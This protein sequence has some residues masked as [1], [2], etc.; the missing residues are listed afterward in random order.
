MS[1]HR[2]TQLVHLAREHNALIITD[3]VYDRLQWPTTSLISTSAS[4]TSAHLDHAILPRLTDLDRAL[5][6]HPSDPRQFR[7][8]LSNG[9]FSKILGPGVR[10]GWADS[11]PA[12]SYG[13]SQCG[14]SRS[15]GCPSQL[16]ATMIAQLLEDGSLD[17]HITEVLIPSYA[18]RWRMMIDAIEICLV[19]LG[20]SVSK[21]S[22]EGKDVFGGY[23]IWFELPEGMSAEQVAVRAKERQNL[24]VAQGDMFEVYGDEQAVRLKRWVRVCFAWEA[25]ELLV[26]GIERLGKVIRDVLSGPVD[27]GVE[28]GEDAQRLRT[29]TGGF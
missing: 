5:P 19:P 11:S 2:R 25:E 9:S 8:T 29:P 24:I 28:Y 23:F 4:S 26:E 22:L 16:V 6:A 1:L 18:R 10:T 3:D 13:L 12:L 17:E 15:G 21:V 14:S 7:H 20:V 27:E